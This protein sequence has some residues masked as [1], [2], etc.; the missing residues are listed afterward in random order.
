MTETEFEMY[1]LSIEYLGIWFRSGDVQQLNI[2]TVC[3]FFVM[4]EKLAHY[5]G[6][7]S[8]C[9]LAAL[10]ACGSLMFTFI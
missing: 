5:Y 1:L 2:S 9:N 6:D 8:L 7:V 3:D 4:F 10:K